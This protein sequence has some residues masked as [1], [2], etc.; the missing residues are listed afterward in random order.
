M[1]LMHYEAL[2]SEMSDSELKNVCLTKARHMTLEEKEFIKTEL[3]K[4]KIERRYSLAVEAQ[5]AL[6]TEKEFDDYCGI[7]VNA[8]CPRCG[9][10]NTPLNSIVVAEVFSVVLFTQSSKSVKIACA[11]CLNKFNRNAL[12]KN[13][14]FGWWGIPWG[15]FKTPQAV[16]F[17]LRQRKLLDNPKPN[18]ELNNFID[19]HV[20]IFAA[21]RKFPEKITQHL[22]LFNRKGTV[23]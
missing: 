20:G 19:L 22:R 3:A 6:Y 13:L 9:N 7:V 17:N 5:K 4:R 8:I 15:L 10:G 1:T 16:W 23:V 21:D 12:L 11:S 14:L 18:P 2:Y